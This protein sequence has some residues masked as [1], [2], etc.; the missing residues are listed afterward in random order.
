LNE[1]KWLSAANAR[2]IG[3]NVPVE[4]FLRQITTG[5]VSDRR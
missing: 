3:L 1:Y 2:D 4:L 5:G